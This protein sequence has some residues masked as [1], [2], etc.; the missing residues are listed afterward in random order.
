MT[1]LPWRSSE[2]ERVF[3]GVLIPRSRERLR[4]GRKE[5]GDP[6]PLSVFLL[7]PEGSLESMSKGFRER[8]GRREERRTEAGHAT[9]WG[10]V[11]RC[12]VR[13][14]HQMGSCE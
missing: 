5:R 8:E 7:S 6:A 13:Q 1:L 14:R 10:C 11:T 4:G 9:R 3:F 12:L 2:V